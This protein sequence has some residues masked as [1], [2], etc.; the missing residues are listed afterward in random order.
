MGGKN[1][2]YLKECSHLHNTSVA[3]CMT[4]LDRAELGGGGGLYVNEGLRIIEN[5]EQPADC[6]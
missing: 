1:S 3:G 4:L 6:Q 2:E 5:R